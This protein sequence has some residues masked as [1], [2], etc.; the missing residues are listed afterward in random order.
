MEQG[1]RHFKLA[2]VGLQRFLLQIPLSCIINNN[3][4]RGMDG[5]FISYRNESYVCIATILESFINGRT[6]IACEMQINHPIVT[7]SYNYN[8]LTVLFIKPYRNPV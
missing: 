1:T 5:Y 2:L 6:Y 4:L 3:F 8:L 7:I